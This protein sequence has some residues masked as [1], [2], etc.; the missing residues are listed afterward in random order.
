MTAPTIGE[1]VQ[2]QRVGLSLAA[3]GYVALF[4]PALWTLGKDWASYEDYSHGF[5]VPLISL[6]ILWANR[7][8][9]A[10]LA[11]RGLPVAGAGLLAV[12]LLV[13][14]F[15]VRTNT[16]LFQRA[17]AWGALLSGVVLAFGSSVLRAKPFPFFFLLVSIPPPYFLL[18]Q[19]RLT[20]KTFATRLSSELLG[21]FGFTAAPE[22]NVLVINGERLEVADACSGIRSLMA[23]VATALLLAY[24]F[25]SG[26]W[27]GALL[28]LTAVPVT[29]LVNV[30]RIVIVAVALASFGIDLT[31]GV[32][33]DVVGFCVFGLSLVFLYASWVFYEWLF[34]WRAK[35]A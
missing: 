4:F 24:L 23:I 20:L 22:G 26:F 8:T 13:F 9:L 28:T 5:L 35:K 25:R 33:H 16:N 17:G 1:L 30:L 15:G 6:V 11:A 34:A 12:A 3:A 32:V 27:K 29:V 19:F 18:G 7:R 21:A 31:H 14:L 10:S 2:Q